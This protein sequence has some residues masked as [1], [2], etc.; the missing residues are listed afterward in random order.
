MKKFLKIFIG[1][2]FATAIFGGFYLFAKRDALLHE[3]L[4][5]PDTINRIEKFASDLIGTQ[6]KVGNFLVEDLN[7]FSMQDSALIVNNIEVF[8]KNNELIAQV[9]KAKVT[10]KLIDLDYLIKGAGIID[11]INITGAQAFIKKRDDN[12]WN[13]QDIKIKDTG[14][15]KFNAEI[16]LREGTVT[17]EFDGK[18]ISVE[19][20]EATADCSDMTAI[21]TKLSAE[22]LGSQINATGTLGSN[23]QIINAI[24][25]TADILK[26]LPYLPENTLPENITIHKGR[27][28][29]IVLNI[30]RRGELLSY[31]GFTDFTNGAVRIEDT[32]ITG[33]SGS[34]TFTDSEYIINASAAANG[35]SA[36]VSGKIRTDTDEMFFDVDAKSD[37]FVPSAI[38]ENIGI[39]GGASFTAHV[40]G[41]VKDPKVE[42]DIKSNYLGYEN[43]SA[44]NISTKLKYVNNAV[45][46]S[47]IYAESFGGS[48]TGEFEITAQTLAYNAHLKAHGINLLAVR[49]YLG[50]DIPVF[51]D[52]DADVALNGTG[53]DLKTLNVYG[54]ASGQNISYQNFLVNNF[55]ASFYLKEDD[56]KF[57][58]LNLTLP[59]HGTINLEGTLVD[60]K[61]LDLDFYAAHVDL[62][63]AKKFNPAIEIS[64]LSDFNGSIHGDIDNPQLTLTLTAIGDPR[65]KLPGK[66]FNQ[67]FDNINLAISGSL[68]AVN[69]ESFELVKDGNKQWQI[70]DGWINFKEQTLNVRL[71]TVGARLEGIVELLAPTQELTGKI[72]NTIRAQGSFK[73][74]DFTNLD[75]VGYVE[76]QYGSYRGFLISS[77]RGDYFIEKGGNFRLQDFEIITPMIDMV[78]NGTINIK[79]FEMDFTVSGREIDLRRFQ[80][81]FPYEVSGTAKFEG[82]ISGNIDAP[83]FDGQ[84]N[85]E[86]LTFNGVDLKN[87]TGHIG[88]TGNTVVLDDVKFNQGRGK[89]EMQL[90]ADIASKAMSGLV[91][92][93][94]ADVEAMAALA[95]KNLKF[96]HGE[97]TSNIEL[98]GNYDNPAVK[99]IGNIEKGAVGTY[100]LHDVLIDLNVLNYVATINNLRGLQGEK[101]VFE[102]S[103][104]ANLYGNLDLLAKATSIEL[105]VFG[106]MAGVDADFVGTTDLHAK[107]TGDINNPVGDLVLSAT[108]GIKGSTFDLLR[109]HVTFKDWIFE[110]VEMTVESAIGEKVY[111]LGAKGTIPVEAFYIENDYP[112]AE[113][114]LQVSLD[115]ANLSLLPV[116]S[117]MVGWA[118]G[119]MAGTLTITGTA[120]NPQINGKIS[121]A[122]GT[123]KINGMKNL[124]EHINISTEFLGNRFFVDD[125]SGNIGAGNFALTGGL[126]FSDFKVS[127]YKFD[128][129]ADALDI[130]S[131]FFSGPLNAE[132]SLTEETFFR[133]TLPKVSGHVDFDKCL[134][135]I[136]AIPDSDDELPEILLDVAIN[137]GDKVHFY[138]S[139]LYNMYLTG[140]VKYEGTTRHPKPSGIISVKRGATLNYISTVFD[141]REGELYFNQMDSFLPSVNFRADTR[142]TDIRVELAVT[143]TLDNNMDIKLTSNPEKS[144]T[145][146][147]QILTLRDA[148]GNQTSNM[149]MADVL[150][151]GLQMSILGDVEDTVKRNLGLDRFI[152]SSGSG[153][154][155]DSFASKEIDTGQRNEEFN[156]SIGKYVTDK[157]MLKYTQGINGERVTRYGFQY[158]INDNLGFTVEKEKREFIFSLEARYKF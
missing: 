8:D 109:G 58:Y 126:N 80:S 12:S 78:L 86:L 40:F 79:S 93:E 145:E 85:S 130:Q 39:D 121:L 3:L 73:N 152:F 94:K 96:L 57:D 56:I 20:I 135:S 55:D 132:F 106:A 59:N 29:N 89:Y 74:F 44:R 118:T 143:G 1:I 50:A 16:N 151:I 141:V 22:T 53:A 5:S 88:A 54:S 113:M 30:L 25:D 147:V 28:N 110:V 138:S 64:G 2:L 127:N 76:M 155:L 154:A 95:N 87:I 157:L 98:G 158:D 67:E 32:E 123:V 75:L 24:I 131:D 108:G 17:A 129:V 84:I 115:E 45:F 43:L 146:I 128:F 51:G 7:L 124:I 105:G 82:L 142:L 33:I 34:S 27:A 42:A 100:D 60:T 14:E 111:K 62:S 91:T 70:M 137:L 61:K 125:F 69:F 72:D 68:D 144:Q 116:L 26:I 31:S 140:N 41:T 83:K 122:D 4:N 120:S 6:V 97:L 107:V 133:R 66:A 139:R 10:F 81:Q 36:T 92:V 13:V 11:E 119:E 18:N 49:N 148:Y 21:E 77:M 150:A 38:I 101:G 103:G 23:K 104:N 19:N 71:D 48:V 9:D 136:P 117:K 102:V 112:G 65:H 114:N 99:L 149:S 52:V 156:I 15:S 35:Q 47:N 90:T 134:F 46:L 63:L 37:Y 153:S